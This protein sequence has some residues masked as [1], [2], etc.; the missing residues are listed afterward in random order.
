MAVTVFEFGDFR[1]DAGRFKLSRAGRDLRLNE[2]RWNCSFCS[3]R[4]G[5]LVTRSEIAGKLWAREVFVDTE[6][7]INT[8]IRKDPPD[9]VRRLRKNRAS[10]KP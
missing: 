6:H 2:S 4:N 1:L 9:S 10:F 3:R 7:G 8:A 5:N